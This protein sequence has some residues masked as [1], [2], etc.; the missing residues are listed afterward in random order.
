MI[1]QEYRDVFEDKTL[2]LIEFGFPTRID[3]TRNVKNA[4]NQDKDCANKGLSWQLVVEFIL[5]LN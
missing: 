3:V 1:D 5:T 4:E 2:F